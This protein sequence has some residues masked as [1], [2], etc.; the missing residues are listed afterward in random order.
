MAPESPGGGRQGRR[1]WL[2]GHSLHKGWTC[3]AHPGHASGQPKTIESI[4]ASMAADPSSWC[5]TWAST[6][7]D[8]SRCSRMRSASLVRGCLS[9]PPRS[10]WLLPPAD[11]RH[12]NASPCRHQGN[13]FEDRRILPRQGGAMIKLLPLAFLPIA[14]RHRCPRPL[15]RLWK[16]SS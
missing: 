6:E 11:R 10:E 2:S 1:G 12:L 7:S 14:T 9:P 13:F 3:S 16:E 8:R 15:E 4:S 5:F